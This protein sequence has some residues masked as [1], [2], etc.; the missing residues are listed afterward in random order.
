MAPRGFEIL[1]PPAEIG[2]RAFGD[3][4]PD[5][6]G[7]SALALLS[8]GAD[9]SGVDAREEDRLA[10]ASPDLDSL[11]VDWLGEVLYW[12]DGKRIVFREFQIDLADTSLQAVAR[13][14]PRD[15]A[16]HDARLI[17]KA[18]TYHQLK[19]YRRAD[20][21]VAEVYLDI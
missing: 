13:G 4:S 6:F 16:R 18:V 19:I 14:E 17:V 10:A 11:M 3:S 5:L 9:L 2:F 12:F 8:I 20:L 7:N 1:D 15:P 21:W